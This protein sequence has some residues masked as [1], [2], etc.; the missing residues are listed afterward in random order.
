MRISL[1][2]AVWLLLP[3]LVAGCDHKDKAQP[4]QALAPPIVDAPPPK[5]ATV[6]KED[7]PP[8]VVGDP[9]PP[10]PVDTKPVEPPKKPVRKPK[11][12]APAATTPPE[13]AA[14]T[15]PPVTPSV[16]AAGELS[17]GGSADLRSETEDSIN[18][19]EKGVNAVT[20]PLSDSELKTVGQIRDFLKQ[21]R[22]A[23]GTGDVDGAQTLV[24]K[25][26]V[27]LAELNQ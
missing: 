10:K 14:V 12:P 16:S 8:P 11:K 25:A 26:K 22:E 9:T 24:K 15:P 19:T 23:L 5:P 4:P 20:R 18:S 2:Y 13:T 7:L 21:A 27:L 6:A 1:K 3:L 17:G